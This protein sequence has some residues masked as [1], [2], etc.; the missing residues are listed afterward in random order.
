ML[1]MKL[2]KFFVYIMDYYVTNTEMVESNVY[3]VVGSE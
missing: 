1:F 2:F 3:V